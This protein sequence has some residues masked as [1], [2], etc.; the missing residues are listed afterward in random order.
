MRDAY[1][2]STSTIGT[3]DQ[4]ER[5]PEELQERALKRKRALSPL[6][7]TD[8]IQET[9]LGLPMPD[10]SDAYGLGGRHSNAAPSLMMGPSAEPDHA[11]TFGDS[12][13]AEPAPADHAPSKPRKRMTADEK[14]KSSASE[15]TTINTPEVSRKR[16][17]RIANKSKT[18]RFHLNEDLDDSKDERGDILDGFM[19]QSGDMSAL[20]T[21]KKHDP[22]TSAATRHEHH[23]GRSQSQETIGAAQPTG[24]PGRTYLNLSNLKERPKTP[25]KKKK[26]ID[27]GNSSA[28]PAAMRTGKASTQIKSKRKA[29]SD[30]AGLGN[31]S[32]SDDN[33]TVARHR[34]AIS[35]SPEPA[36]TL[37]VNTTSA[38]K[39]M[40]DT[41]AANNVPSSPDE[42]SLP[43]RF[44]FP[45]SR[46]ANAASSLQ[47]D[48]VLESTE[49]DTYRS[50]LSQF[51]LD[52]GGQKSMHDPFVDLEDDDDSRPNRQQKQLRLD[53]GVQK[54]LLK[55]V[56]ARDEEN[57]RPIRQP[58]PRDFGDV[59]DLRTLKVKQLGR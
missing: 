20:A 16:R 58:K 3:Y 24:S 6:K 39:S 38:V 5:R 32:S 19:S 27:N 7:T 22:S 12:A 4:K 44:R 46:P 2:S 54:N 42:L 11:Q 21:D 35:E 43:S 29:A 34:V 15:F 10:Q 23:D 49:G 56:A 55:T 33:I 25:K 8:T 28:S 26:A 48:F 59:V 31:A 1:P 9:N 37:S 51:N 47:S 18:V 36:P 52:K 14:A 53:K 13:T 41:Y 40:K 17:R 45:S 50:L 57:A 30:S